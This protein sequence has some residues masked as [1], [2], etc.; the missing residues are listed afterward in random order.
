MGQIRVAGF[1]EEAVGQLH[2]SDPLPLSLSHEWE[3][4]ANS[5]RPCESGQG[6]LRQLLVDDDVDSRGAHPDRLAE[7]LEIAGL[8]HGRSGF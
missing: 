8:G 4:E 5:H 3:R 1:E 2:W 6:L 7:A